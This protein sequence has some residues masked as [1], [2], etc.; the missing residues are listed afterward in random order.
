MELSWTS[1]LPSLLAIV[2]AIVT[3][4]VLLALIGGIILANILLFWP[5]P[6][7]IA[8]GTLNSTWDTL[9]DPSNMLVWFFTLGI[10]ALFGVLENGGTFKQF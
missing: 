2:F 4:K 1:L 3:R 7:N 10:G 5:A 6:E 9:V 8:Y